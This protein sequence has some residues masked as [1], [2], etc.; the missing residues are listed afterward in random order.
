MWWFKFD[1]AQN[2]VMENIIVKFVSA[3]T[4]IMYLFLVSKSEST[5]L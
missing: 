5:S 3:L 4:K 1:E 2:K